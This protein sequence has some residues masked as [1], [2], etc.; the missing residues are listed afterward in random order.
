MTSSEE[1]D[2]TNCDREPIHMPGSVQAHGCLLVLDA[3]MRRVLRH[4]RNA[5][6]FLGL[7]LEDCNGKTLD[8]LFGREGAHDLRNARAR[9]SGPSRPGITSGL[10]LGKAAHRFDV[11]VHGHEGHSLIEFEIADDADGSGPLEIA[12]LAISRIQTIDKLDLLIERTPRLILALL[13][14]DRVMLYR[15]A[16]DGSGQVVS[17]ARRSLDIL[18]FMG[19]HFPASDIPKQA[20]QLYLQNMIRVIGD[21]SGKTVPIEPVLDH[22]GQPLDLSFAHLRSVSPIHTEYLRNMG[23]AASMSISVVVE[24][25]LWG[26]IACHHHGPRHLGMP[27]RIAAEMF[28]DVFSLK[29]EALKQRAALDSAMHAR[30]MLETLLLDL[31]SHQDVT[32]F[33]RSR[34]KDLGSL[35]PSDGVG[36]F[37]NGIWSSEGAAP[38]KRSV[39]RLAKFVASVA[40]GGIWASHALSSVFPEAAEF[41]GEAS[42]VLAIPLSQIPR[43][44]LFFFRRE[45]IRTLEWAGNPDKQYAVGR[46]GDRLT[47]RA[48]FAI[49]TQTVEQQSLPWTPS[50]RSTAESIRIQLLE[51]IMRHSELLTS[52]RRKAEIRQKVLHEELNHRVKNILAL[53]KSLVSQPVDTERSIVDYVDALK[54]RIMALAFA[55]DQIIRQNG[56]GALADLIS[57]ELSPYRDSGPDIYTAGPGISLDGRALSVLALVLHEM[58]TNAAKYGALSR[59]GGRLDLVWEINA[60][61]DCELTW[62][63]SGGPTVRAPDRQGF[64]S[65]LLQRS[66]PFDLGGISEIDYPPTGVVARF[67]IPAKFVHQA[68][69]SADVAHRASSVHV[70][71]VSVLKDRTVLLVEDQLVIALDVENMLMD[72]GARTVH[73][74]ATPAEALGALAHLT[75][76]VAV[77]DIDLGSSTSIPVAE[78]LQARGIPFVFATGYGDSAMIPPSLA[79]AYVLRKPYSTD[80][81][82]DG[83]TQTLHGRE[84]RRSNAR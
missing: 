58:V 48:S 9:A 56:G 29:L 10:A 21:A 50:D 72:F 69:R 3:D 76:D 39:A 42:G 79:D 27:R 28:G 54:G 43:D 23:V 60:D 26:L 14:Y 6:S 68:A 41:A 64:G 61:G 18:S 7:P 83:L 15:F 35:L 66:I 38:P 37:M 25:E 40:E 2:L 19:Q 47:P 71:N 59:A 67:V 84:M 55:H 57:A 12:R 13:G 1:V 73:T 51:I 31:A 4:S 70:G 5:A 30:T 52:E 49:W 20:R 11:S 32:A 33:L 16:E 80:N 44:F 63:E 74:F 78:E 45:Q 81:L 17:E 53:I 82:R 65:M 34:L 62:T 22:S 24:G 77:L 8:D 46:R 75:P 36:L